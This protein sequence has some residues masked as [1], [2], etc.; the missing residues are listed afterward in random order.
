MTPST[1]PT[2]AITSDAVEASLSIDDL[3]REVGMSVRNLREWRALGI[4]PPPT[5]VG[6][7]GRYGSE[8]VERV[9]QAQRLH[10]DGFPLEL[11]R[12]ILD[13]DETLADDVVR[14]AEAL[15]APLRDDEADAIDPF[16]LASRWGSFPPEHVLRARELGLV[17]LGDDGSLAFTNQ[18]VARVGEVMSRMGLSLDEVLD[19]TASVRGHLDAIAAT[20]EQ[21]WLDH[22]WEPFVAD[23]MPVEDRRDIEDLINE[24]PHRAMD[25]VIGL[26]TVAMRE[27]IESGIERETKRALADE[28]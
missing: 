5:M 25:A 3:A 9:R 24:M 2:E 12:R 14:L 16:A 17:E 13:A 21:V 28:D 22:V 6:R 8:V 15:R 7:A 4:L 23:G 1:A 10:A 20:L 19:A 26:F 18:R 27:R 11:V